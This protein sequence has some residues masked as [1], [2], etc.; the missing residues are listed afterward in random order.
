[1]NIIPTAF[2]ADAAPQAGGDMSMIIVLTVCMV[3]V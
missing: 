3:A 2:A 1:M